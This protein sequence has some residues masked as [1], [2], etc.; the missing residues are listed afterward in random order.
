MEYELKLSNG[1]VVSWVGETG[2]D[3]AK[4]YA[5]AHRESKL[6]AWR[7]KPHGVF[8]YNHNFKMIE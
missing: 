1:K 2:E 5:D 3:A 7:P 8:I 4:R 6:V